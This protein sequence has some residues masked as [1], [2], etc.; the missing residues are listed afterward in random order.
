MKRRHHDPLTLVAEPALGSTT[1]NTLSSVG[2]AP[3]CDADQVV[4]LMNAHI[5]G[6]GGSG[7][8]RCC[9][10]ARSL[11]IP[12]PITHLTPMET[13]RKAFRIEQRQKLA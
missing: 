1:A 11:P 6:H 10:R 12:F 7:G 9:L 5:P 2:L 8:Q 4:A 3:L 13:S